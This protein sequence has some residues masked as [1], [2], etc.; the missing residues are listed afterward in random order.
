[1]LYN[2]VLVSAV[3]QHESAIGEHMSSPSSTSL[4]SPTPSNSSRLSQS[5]GF[6]LPASYSKFPLLIYLACGHV[7]VSRHREQTCGYSEGRRG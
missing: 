3:H 5:T 1:M 7:Y 4:S 2:I 6:E